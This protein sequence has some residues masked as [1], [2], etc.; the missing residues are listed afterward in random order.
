MAIRRITQGSINWQQLAEHVSDLQRPQLNAFKAKYDYYY[1][2]CM[3]YP[4]EPPKIDWENLKKFIL[5]PGMVDNFKNQYEAMQ[6][7]YPGESV[8]PQINKYEQEVK[9]QIE[10][11]KEESN[12]RIKQS[13]SELEYINSLI[14]FDQMTM[15]DYKD[16][17]PNEALDVFKKPT[18]WPHLP[19]EQLG[20][21]EPTPEDEPNEMEKLP[22]KKQV[23]VEDKSKVKEPPKL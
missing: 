15:D 4:Q 20:Y 14:P 22:N 5:A 7:P 11:F 16:A 6:V 8:S 13:Q 1:R 17:Y 3:S 19:E 21:K 23:L 2:I 10:K 18:F 12:A 9:E